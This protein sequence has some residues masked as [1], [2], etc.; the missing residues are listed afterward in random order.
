[1]CLAAR[2]PVL[3]WPRF[4]SRQHDCERRC[5][6]RNLAALVLQ[7][8]QQLCLRAE[9]W[10]VCR[11]NISSRASHSRLLNGSFRLQI[12]IAQEYLVICREVREAAENA[13]FFVVVV[14]ALRPF[15]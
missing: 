9:P 2:A 12:K 4:L 3:A 6:S 15:R 14:I 5:G 8:P 10:V 7:H 1:R 13:G 11:E